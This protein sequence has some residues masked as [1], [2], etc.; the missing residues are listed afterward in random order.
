MTPAAV[1]PDRPGP[2]HPL[3]QKITDGILALSLANLCFFNAWNC[4]LREKDLSYF[5]KLPL[6][7]ATLLAMTLNL[8]WFAALAWLGMRALRRFPHRWFHLLGQCL[9]LLVLLLPLNAGLGLA[10]HWTEPDI[11]AFLKRPVG[12]VVALLLLACVAW[13][14]RWFVRAALI[15][16]SIMSPL[17]FF[18]LARLALASFGPHHPAHHA[19]APA[20][21]PL[22]PLRPG[23][24]RVVWMIF[25]EADQRL[26]FD[27]RPPTV[28]LPEFDR[29]RRESLCATNAYPPGRNTSESIPGLISGN[30]IS[31]VS[32]RGASDLALTLA[33][34]GKVAAWSELPSVFSSAREMGVNTGLVGMF[35]PYSRVLGRSLNS[36]NWYP[37]PI[38]EPARALTVGTAMR[39]QIGCLAWSLHFRQL[40]VELCRATL[41]DS[42]SVVTNADYGLVFLH[43]PPPHRP[44]VFNPATGQFTLFDLSRVT[45]YF[46]NLALADRT[47]GTL[48]QAMETSGQSDKTWLIV[49]A[50]H[51]WR[52]SSL[53]DGRR[54]FRVPFLLKAPGPGQSITCSLPI[55]TSLTHDL[56]LA[57]LRGELTDDQQAA[58]WLAAHRS[59]AAPPSA[60]PLAA[61]QPESD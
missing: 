34:T 2:L 52:E 51:S 27:Q 53:Y 16:T 31:A 43:L 47:L 13:K 40:F 6:T 38:Y 55:N 19:T 8:F 32:L 11:V 36:C 48:R 57:V 14:R 33:D 60:P 21:A 20:L 29:L 59:I 9:F 42:L 61:G 4:V 44:G 46:D 17:A 26:I 25:D 58:A 41:A 30:R 12:A 7:Q 22:S 24:P 28:Q 56:V 45:G 35:H 54:D 37:Y 5:Q 3:W 39:H 18:T 49:S 15:V 23:Q 10:F 50:D 1:S